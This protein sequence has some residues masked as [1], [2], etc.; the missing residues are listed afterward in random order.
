MFLATGPHTTFSVFGSPYSPA[1][2]LWAF[3]YQEEE[4][5][6]VWDS[7]PLSTDI[8]VTHA[9]PKHHCDTSARGDSDGC[10]ALRRVLWR[11]RP[12]LAVCGHRHEGRGVERV[13]WNLDTS[14]EA[15]TALE[16]ATET[17]VDP[18]EGN[19]KI[20]RVDLTMK[21]GKMIANADHII[22]QTCVVNAAITAA[23]YG[24]PGR[25]RLNKPIVVDLEL[26][27]W[28]EK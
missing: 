24:R 6:K 13:L 12:K 10:E 17:W 1:K 20:S 21:G 23:S 9:P 7:M 19:K 25:M 22:G 16:E 5:D 4:G 8:A 18:G 3:G 27:V 2:G 14:S 15:T 11:V 26:P 28:E